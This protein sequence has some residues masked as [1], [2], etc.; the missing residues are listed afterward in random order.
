[1]YFVHL[2]SIT[3]NGYVSCK[4]H[5][6]QVLLTSVVPHSEVAAVSPIRSQAK[7]KL[8]SWRWLVGIDCAHSLDPLPKT[9]NHHCNKDPSRVKW[10]KS[11][12]RV[13]KRSGGWRVGVIGCVL[14]DRAHPLCSITANRAAWM[15]KGSLLSFQSKP[16]IPLLM[17]LKDN[18]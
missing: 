7:E 5:R 16:R 9:P 10:I 8:V 15:F 1:M 11:S 3:F 2:M 4:T 17:Q 6:R 18:F 14:S 13:K 12:R